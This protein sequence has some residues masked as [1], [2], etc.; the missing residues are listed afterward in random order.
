AGVDHQQAKRA[1]IAVDAVVAVDV[2]LGAVDDFHA[3]SAVV[4]DHVFRSRSDPIAAIEYQVRGA[5]RDSQPA[6]A[7]DGGAGHVAV[8]VERST[9][10]AHARTRAV[11]DGAVGD[12]HQRIQA[13]QPDAGAVLD[14]DIGEI[15]ARL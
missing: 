9:V 3:Y 15:H 7:R 2:A 8:H 4:A 13:G 6:V 10:H 12:V 1:V 11:L 5:G 14:G